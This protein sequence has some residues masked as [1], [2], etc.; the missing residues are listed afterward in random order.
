MKMKQSTSKSFGMLAGKV[1]SEAK[2]LP[3]KTASSGRSI[4]AEFVAGFQEVSSATKEEG[5]KPDSI[6]HQ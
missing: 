2:A 1:V 4:K 6:T 3:K 5:V